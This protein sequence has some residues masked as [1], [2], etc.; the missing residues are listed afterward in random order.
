LRHSPADG[1]DDVIVHH[2]AVERMGVADHHRS[3]RPFPFGHAAD[4]LKGE[5]AA[6]KRYSGLGQG[7]NQRLT[8]ETLTHYP[9]SRSAEPSGTL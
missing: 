4:A 3:K 1:D 8:N 9:F 7:S 5:V 6:G 2:A